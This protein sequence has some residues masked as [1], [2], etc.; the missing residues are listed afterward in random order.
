MLYYTLFADILCDVWNTGE[1]TTF[2]ATGYTM[3]SLALVRC[4]PGYRFADGSLI[5]AVVCLNSGYWSSY[6]L[7][8][9]NKIVLV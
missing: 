9:S 8:Q 7:C 5:R 1:G 6:Q 4:E 3:D 2:E